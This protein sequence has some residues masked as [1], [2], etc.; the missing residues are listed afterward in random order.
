M[1]N[2]VDKFKSLHC[3]DLNIAPSALYLL[4]SNDVDADTRDEFIERAHL[5]R[6]QVTSGHFV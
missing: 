3:E 2:V 4:A 1:M 6:F 5:E